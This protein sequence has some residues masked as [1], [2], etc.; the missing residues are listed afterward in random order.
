[1]DR[2]QGKHRPYKTL[3]TI[4]RKQEFTILQCGVVDALR[5]RFHQGMVTGASVGSGFKDSLLRGVA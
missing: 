5:R 2:G 1:M 4:A 3:K